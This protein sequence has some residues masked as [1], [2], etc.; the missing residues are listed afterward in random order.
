MQVMTSRQQSQ[1][2]ILFPPFYMSVQYMLVWQVQEC[3]DVSEQVIHVSISENAEQV[4]SV[5]GWRCLE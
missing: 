1:L 2:C 3:L 5:R 4:Y